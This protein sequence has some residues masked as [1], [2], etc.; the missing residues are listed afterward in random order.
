M[1]HNDYMIR[2]RGLAQIVWMISLLVLAIVLPVLSKMVRQNQD[3]RRKATETEC[4]DEGQECCLGSDGKFFC[5]VGLACTMVAVDDGGGGSGG[6][7]RPA[8]R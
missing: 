3:M 2:K 1:C 8:A 5:N 4:G 6:H 7:G